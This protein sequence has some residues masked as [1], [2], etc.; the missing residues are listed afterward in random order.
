MNRDIILFLS[1]L[2]HAELM[3]SQTADVPINYWRCAVEMW[4]ST[5]EPVHTTVRDVE[6]AFRLRWPEIYGSVNDS[7]LYLSFSYVDYLFTE[8]ED[9]TVSGGIFKRDGVKPTVVKLNMTPSQIVELAMV[10]RQWPNS[11]ILIENLARYD[12]AEEYIQAYS[13]LEYRNVSH[14]MSESEALHQ[15]AIHMEEKATALN[16]MGYFE[17]ALEWFQKSIL[18]KRAAGL[19]KDGRSF[20]DYAYTSMGRLYEMLLDDELADTCYRY[21]YNACFKGMINNPEEDMEGAWYRLREWASM[22][23]CFLNRIGR[24]EEAKRIKNLPGEYDNNQTDIFSLTI[25]DIEKA[26]GE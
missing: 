11:E 3:K 10:L 6:D 2:P 24:I 21:A 12:Q 14:P 18:T 8:N 26:S 4:N 25:E 19:E 9:G 5:H 15:K 23:S 16:E 7:K 22:Y 13:Q 17:E 20:S 1:Q